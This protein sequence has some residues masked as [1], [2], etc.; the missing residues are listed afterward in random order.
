M[1]RDHHPVLR[2][3]VYGVL[4]LCVLFNSGGCR[5]EIRGSGVGF[6]DPRDANNS[7]VNYFPPGDE[8]KLQSNTQQR[9]PELQLDRIEQGL[10]SP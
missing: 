2:I 7:D 10:T 9:S 5:T 6:G 8:F 4:V 1:P 3:A